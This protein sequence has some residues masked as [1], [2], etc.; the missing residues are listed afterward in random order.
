M[1]GPAGSSAPPGWPWRSP[2]LPGSGAVRRERRAAPRWSI[3][4]EVDIE[5]KWFFAGQLAAGKSSPNDHA[6]NSVIDVMGGDPSDHLLGQSKIR[7]TMAV[8]LPCSPGGFDFPSCPSTQ[9][10]T[11]VMLTTSPQI[12]VSSSSS[13]NCRI[14]Q[15]PMM[16]FRNH[17]LLF[18]NHGS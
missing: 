18:R 15:K 1:T 5:T 7:S 6:R 12:F 13:R 8:A 17:G 3:G 11:S 10:D 14:I 16:G 2:R 9:Y 4:Q